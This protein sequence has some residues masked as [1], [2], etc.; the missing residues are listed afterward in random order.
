MQPTKDEVEQTACVK[1]PPW[2]K[3]GSDFIWD[4][5]SGLFLVLVTWFRLS[6]DGV[7]WMLFC[8]KMQDISISYLEI[9][10]M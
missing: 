2:R 6:V 1:F 5:G 3:R 9:T 7:F 8:A 10:I 4:H